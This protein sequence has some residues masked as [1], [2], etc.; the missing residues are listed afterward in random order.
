MIEGIAGV[1][2]WTDNV[3][4]LV[5]FYLDVL[6]LTPHSVRPDFVAFSFGDARLS[7]GRHD[8]VS[9][10]AKDPNRVMVNLA[11]TDIQQVYTLL[12]E[13]GVSFLRPPERERWGGWVATFHDPDGNILQLLQQPG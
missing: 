13:K 8:G 10:K 5:A 3:E 1:I 4:R 2:L 12:Q 7:I 11:V 9:G 6:G